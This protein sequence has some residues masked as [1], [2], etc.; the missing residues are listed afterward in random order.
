MVKR[1][2]LSKAKLINSIVRKFLKFV[3][4]AIC[5]IFNEETSGI[6]ECNF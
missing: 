6:D 4:Q 1:T 2:S 3:T 5:L